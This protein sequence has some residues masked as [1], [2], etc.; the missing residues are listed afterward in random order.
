M[1][2]DYVFNAQIVKKSERFLNIYA[3]YLDYD[4]CLNIRRF[5]VLCI[6]LCS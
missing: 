1:F 5:K 2:E 6:C 4:H 3:I